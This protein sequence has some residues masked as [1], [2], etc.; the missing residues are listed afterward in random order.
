MAGS[1][2]SSRRVT[3]LGFISPRSAA[4]LLAVFGLLAHIQQINY[5]NV[6]YDTFPHVPNLKSVN[7]PLSSTSLSTGT[8]EK[9]S[10]YSQAMLSANVVLDSEVNNNTINSNNT[11]AS[12]WKEAAAIRPVRWFNLLPSRYQQSDANKSMITAV[13]SS[14]SSSSSTTTTTTNAGSSA[15]VEQD[16]KARQRDQE[17]DRKSWEAARTLTKV[18]QLYAVLCAFTCICGIVGVI[19]VSLDITFRISH[20]AS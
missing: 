19:R 2:T 4:L 17:E 14:S 3:C 10:T 15:F 9:D 7:V 16:W 12:F 8:L 1:P 6:L 11:K 18:V 20:S 5:L 13:S